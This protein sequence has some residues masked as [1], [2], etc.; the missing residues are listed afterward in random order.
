MRSPS[1]EFYKKFLLVAL[2]FIGSF[3]VLASDS[4]AAYSRYSCACSNGISLE[5]YAFDSSTASSN[6]SSLCSSTYGTPSQPVTLNSCV[7]AQ[8]GGSTGSTGSTGS[9]GGASG[10]SNLSYDCKCRDATQFFNYPGIQS[11]SACDSAC[12][13]HGG[14]SYYWSGT[15][16]QNCNI[17]YSQGRIESLDACL[18]SCGGNAGGTTCSPPC[19]QFAE[20]CQQNPEDGSFS[21]VSKSAGGCPGGCT[22]G[23]ECKWDDTDRSWSCEP[24]SG[25]TQTVDCGGTPCNGIC[26]FDDAGEPLCVP[27]SNQSQMQPGQ[28]PGSS[29]SQMQS[30]TKYELPN[31]LGVKT[32]SQLITKIAKFL[33]AL[34]IPFAVFMVILAGFRFA[35]AQ[36]NEEKLTKAK[37]NFIWTIAGVAII[38]ASEALILYIEELLG[39]SGGGAVNAFINK[40]RQTLNSVI[41]ILFILVTIYFCWGVIQYVVGSRGDEEKLTQG[42]RHMIWGIVGMTVMASAWGIVGIISAYL[43]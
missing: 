8:S 35:T 20:E 3:L 6:G 39:A 40:I 31:P 22:A 26:T 37:Q 42:K 27:G 34:A 10:S 28:L 7:L 12:T 16:E 5:L 4:N 32:I 14:S 23:N 38:L 18:A 25:T 30:G 13:S 21:C 1:T 19:D 29:Q 17:E 9:A 2:L 41:V 43:R 36:G 11:S 33:I 24:V 15:C